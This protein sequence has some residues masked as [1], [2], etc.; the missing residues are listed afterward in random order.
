MFVVLPLCVWESLELS[1]GELS[2]VTS[3]SLPVSASLSAKISESP[4]CKALQPP[5]KKINESFT[6]ECDDAAHLD[7]YLGDNV[8]GIKRR[9]RE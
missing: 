9:T 1:L 2:G 3:Q 5:N 4:F 6:L 7:T 8:L